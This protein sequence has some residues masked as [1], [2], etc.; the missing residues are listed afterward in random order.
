[1][2]E[3]FSLATKHLHLIFDET[4]YKQIDGAAMGSPLAPTLANT[5]LFYHEKKWLQRCPLE[6]RPIY[7][8]R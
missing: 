5:F 1:M 8:R 6:Y 7:H 2:K 3:F 4:L